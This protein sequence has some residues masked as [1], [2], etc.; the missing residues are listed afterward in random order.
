MTWILQIIQLVSQL[1]PSVS[2]G[3]RDIIDAAHQNKEMTDEEHAALVA[4]LH[5]KQTEDPAWQPSPEY[6][7]SHPQP[8]TTP[9]A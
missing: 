9:T 4:E 2:K 7:A 5:R 6:L 3:V 8:T 1:A